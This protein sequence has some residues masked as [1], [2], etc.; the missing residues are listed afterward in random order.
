MC[1]LPKVFAHT[2]RISTDIVS[3]I[4]SWPFHSLRDS[5]WIIPCDNTVSPWTVSCR[6]SHDVRLCSIFRLSRV[7]WLPNISQLS[8]ILR[9]P[10]D[11]GEKVKIQKLRYMVA[12]DCKFTVWIHR[13][14]ICVCVPRR[15]DRHRC[16]YL[17][18]VHPARG[19]LQPPRV[20]L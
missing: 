6:F 10:S 15:R 20:C 1:S 19:N 12:D 13:V 3:P 18:L 7:S 8:S 17:N 4:S 5:K 2:I 16:V 14:W 11:L 9:A